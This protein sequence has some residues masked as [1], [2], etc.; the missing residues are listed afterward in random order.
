MLKNYLCTCNYRSCTS[1]PYPLARSAHALR[2]DSLGGGGADRKP[3]AKTSRRDLATVRHAT[4]RSGS[5][6]PHRRDVGQPDPVQSGGTPRT[7]PVGSAARIAIGKGG[8]SFKSPPGSAGAAA[9]QAHARG[10]GRKEGGAEPVR[11]HGVNQTGAG[12][13]LIAQGRPSAAPIRQ[14]TCIYS[15]AQRG[16]RQKIAFG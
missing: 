10:M 1:C 9:T 11:A 8:V 7:V 14:Y 3:A 13:R 2:G 4:R 16:E 6:Q 12:K 15:G 5:P